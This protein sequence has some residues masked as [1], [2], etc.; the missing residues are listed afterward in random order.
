M[1][2]KGGRRHL[3]REPAPRFWPIHRKEYAWTVKPKPGPHALKHSLPL[4]VV[5]RDILGFAKTRK[6]AKNIISQGKIL[7]DG[8]ARK[9]AA[10]PIGLMDVISIPEA[11]AS[12]RVLSHE[13]GLILHPVEKEETGFKLCRIENKK[14]LDHGHVQLNLHD[15]TNKLIR[16]ADPK[17]PNEDV[18][19]TLDAVKVAIPIGEITG[20][21]KLTK[22]APALIIDGQNRGIHGKILEIE[23]VSGKKRRS[24]LTT[25]E[26]SSGKR[27]QTI[28]DFVFVV[29]DGGQSI[30]F[31]EVK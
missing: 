26:D 8:Q 20:R 2:K 6:E 5:V 7:V 19:E 17:K 22:N 1:G 24:L 14:V 11:E 16:V 27:F 9:E 25:I 4:A 18:Y 31:P 13:K 15:G 21:I 23:D 12:Y 28:L 3:K 30:S 10:F 29:G